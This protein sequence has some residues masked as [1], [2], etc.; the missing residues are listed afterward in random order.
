MAMTNPWGIGLA[1]LAF[2]CFAAGAPAADLAGTWTGTWT[3]D[4]DALVV[5]VT[6]D[7]SQQGV[8]GF[9][10]SDAL[11]VSQIPFGAT[12]YTPP[13][14]HFVLAG[15]ST[16]SVF[17]GTLK[18]DLVEGSFT[19]AGT[20]GSF[21]LVRTHGTH[22]AVEAREV[23][24]GNGKVTLAGTLL[25]P[26]GA[27]P[28]PA[29]L[30]LHGSGAEGRWAN[31]YLA[32]RFLGAGFAALITDKR[33]VSQSTGDWH[34]AGFEDLAED[35]ASGIRFLRSQPDIDGRKIGVYG[36]SQGGTLAPLV[37][38]RA[39]NVAFVIGS[40]AG[41]IDLADMEEYSVGNSIGVPALPPDEA[42]DAKSFVR[43]IVDV[44]Y[45]GRSR[46]ELDLLAARFKG[47]AWYF[48]P[49]PPENFYWSFARRIAA[50]TPAAYWRQVK[51]PVLLL[52]GER[53]ERV[54][55]VRSSR[56]IVAALHA[57]GNRNVTLRMFPGA[58]HTFSLPTPKGGWP[59]HVPDYADAMIAWARD[60]T[61]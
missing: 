15:D 35:G 37:A 45:R 19:E 61:K 54:P 26:A 31:R 56:A 4:G 20:K 53:D 43:A 6:F 55:P 11:Q 34:T 46:G 8:S 2:A 12:S 24:F 3:K 7:Q 40:A 30:F 10:D 28:H 50:Y 36:H 44:G 51:A 48:D 29:V 27:G 16:T 13:H 57:G 38:T 17:D 41:G 47:R 58:D 21:R 59:K 18:G 9:F 22:A 25:V 14:V 42:A 33:G 1:L 32:E 5:T 49:P 39:G 60:K 52:F 23:A